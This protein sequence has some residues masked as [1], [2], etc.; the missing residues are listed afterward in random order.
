[1]E[2]YLALAQVK[3]KGKRLMDR[4]IGL[5]KPFVKRK[6]NKGERVV[7]IQSKN[8]RMGMASSARSSTPVTWWN[9]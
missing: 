8:R 5:R 6:L 3:I 4:V 7:V 2:E 1:M 9:A